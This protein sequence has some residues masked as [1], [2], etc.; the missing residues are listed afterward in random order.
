MKACFDQMRGID[1]EVKDYLH[2]WQFGVIQFGIIR[3][4]ASPA[5]IPL[6]FSRERAAAALCVFETEV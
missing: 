1:D 4:V 6:F 3:G 5:Q 2:G